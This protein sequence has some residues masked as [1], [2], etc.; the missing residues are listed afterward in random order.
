MIIF[1]TI[2]YNEYLSIDSSLITYSMRRLKVIKLTKAKLFRTIQHYRGKKY[3]LKV[4][5]EQEQYRCL[6]V[7]LAILHLKLLHAL[8]IYIHRS[9]PVTAKIYHKPYKNWNRR[10]VFS[11][12]FEVLYDGGGLSELRLGSATSSDSGN[13]SCVP[14]NVRP[15][16]VVIHVIT[17]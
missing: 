10:R 8:Y 15:A 4:F 16:W 7:I 6:E 1:P 3:I 2:K 5:L 14:S 13:Y 9:A 11:L 17:G 12:Q